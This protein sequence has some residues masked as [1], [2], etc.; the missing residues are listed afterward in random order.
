MGFNDYVLLSSH[1]LVDLI[2]VIDL[3]CA[4]YYPRSSHTVS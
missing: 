3:I 4:S 1:D 2:G